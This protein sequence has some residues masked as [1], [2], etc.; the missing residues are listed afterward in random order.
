MVRVFAA[1]A[2]A[3][4]TRGA[5]V[6][7]SG[8]PSPAVGGDAA[9]ERARPADC[10]AA[11]V[12]VRGALLTWDVRRLVGDD[13]PLPSAE[14]HDV[15]AAIDWFGEV[16]GEA[17]LADLEAAAAASAAR[18]ALSGASDASSAP[19]VICAEPE[20]GPGPES[21]SEPELEPET[22]GLSE[23]GRDLPDV[24]GRAAGIVTDLARVALLNWMVAWWPA[25]ASVPALAPEFV[26]AEGAVAADR[27]EDLLDDDEAVGRALG[28]AVGVTGA[29]GRAREH[30]AIAADA[31]TFA[32]RVAELA[33]AVGAPTGAGDIAGTDTGADTD[34]SP[35]G[36][37]VD[38]RHA[39]ATR[40]RDL[41]L[42]AGGSGAVGVGAG[43]VEIATG[44]SPVRWADVPWQTIAADVDATWGLLQS[45]GALSL[46]ASVAAAPRPAFGA[47][48]ARPGVVQARFGGGSAAVELELT[49]SGGQYQGARDAPTEAALTPPA[50]RVLR[51]W[52][53]RMIGDAGIAGEPESGD[54]RSAAVA[55]AAGRLANP[56]AAFAPTFAER[57]AAAAAAKAGEHGQRV[58]GVGGSRGV[59][60]GGGDGV[61]DG[62][63]GD[64]DTWNEWDEWPS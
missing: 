9:V 48:D 19:P 2:G 27:V 22:D 3:G 44:T 8:S 33:D 52:D 50:E 46:A 14:V 40:Q 29:L 31:E 1:E 26:H 12:E 13:V 17:A 41:A 20:S 51:V 58:G 62:A 5:V 45:G 35:A 18:N 4:A 25:G 56:A 21:E 32:A 61:A 24:P 39:G 64:G 16:Y 28:L 7:E 43:A 34:A 38:D 63:A 10:L 47:A 55:Y 37:P 57:A 15:V 36:D 53:R 11:V 30:P 23:P 54:D 6:G 59:D 42:A 60:V 49:L